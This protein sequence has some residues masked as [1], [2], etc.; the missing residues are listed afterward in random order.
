MKIFKKILLVVVVL[1]MA[2]GGFLLKTFYDAGEFSKIQSHFIGNCEAVE[3][4]LSSEDITIHPRTGVAFISSDDRRQP[5]EG[6][7]ARRGAILAYNL[8]AQDPQLVDLTR[9]FDGEFRPHGIGLLL[10]EEGNDRLFVVNHRS[11][12][13]FVEIFEYMGDRLVHLESVSGDQMHSP[14]DVIPVGPRAFYVTND[15]GSAEGIGRTLADLF[16]TPC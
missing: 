13:H 11:D 16:V 14:N 3:G 15:H 5:P 8:A 9:E 10:G 2:L 12:G 4:V 1:A 7:N 6:Q